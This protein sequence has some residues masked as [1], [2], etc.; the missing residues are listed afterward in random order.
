MLELKPILVQTILNF[1]SIIIG[2]NNVCS[3][4]LKLDV[5]AAEMLENDIIAISETH[6]ESSI[7]NDQISLTCFH[8]PL[9]R[10]RNRYV[11]GVALY[12][13][14]N[15]HFTYRSDLESTHIVILWAEINACGKKFLVGVLYRPP[16]SKVE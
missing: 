14:K 8:P 16:Q 13:S 10:D 11:G 15:L 2:H 6:L 9:R 1:E 3:L 5:I 4:Y 7:D 12:I